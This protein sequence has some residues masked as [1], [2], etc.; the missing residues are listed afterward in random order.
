MSEMREKIRKIN[1]A[2]MKQPTKSYSNGIL[3]PL[4]SAKLMFVT[5]QLAQDSS[6]NVVAPNDVIEQTKYILGHISDILAEAEM[7]LDDVVKVQIFVKNIEDSA[8]ISKIRDEAFINSKP[9][10]TM[11]EVTRFLKP[12]YCV[13]IEVTAVKL[14]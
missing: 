11:V 3:I 12:E 1:P 7:T 4:G 8:Q 6:G 13:E 14:K 2:S 5:G 10:S 9:A